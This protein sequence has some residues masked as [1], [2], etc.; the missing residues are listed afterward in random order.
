MQIIHNVK[1]ATLGNAGVAIFQTLQLIALIFFLSKEEMGIFAILI[2]IVGFAQLFVDA[3]LS[4]AILFYKVTDRETLG[5]LYI[6]NIFVGF[7]VFIFTFILSYF[8]GYIYSK[9]LIVFIQLVSVVFLI[10]SFGVQ[11][12]VLFQKDLMFDTLAKYD[13]FSNLLGFL[14]LFLFL[15]MNF[16]LFSFCYSLIVQFLI[17]NLL[18]VKKGKF[19]YSHSFSNLSMSKSREVLKFGFYQLGEKVANYFAS[20]VDV[21][22]IGR[23]LGLEVLGVYSIFKNILFKIISLINP[24]VTKISYTY[25]VKLESNADIKNMYFSS[26][27]YVCLIT[28][29]IYI[30]IASNSKFLLYI[31]LVDYIQ[32]NFILFFLSIYVALRAI[33]NPIGSLILALGKPKISFYWNIVMLIFMPFLIYFSS[34]YG[35]MVLV[36]SL[37][38]TF[39]ILKFFEY[40]FIVKVYTNPSSKD[41]IDSIFKPLIY[42]LVACGCALPSFLAENVYVK[43]TLFI[44]VFVLV[45][46]LIIKFFEKTVFANFIFLI[47][48][49]K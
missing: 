13:I 14:L 39:L 46:L 8:L 3:G 2:A 16:G 28:I 5:F 1:W 20:Q 45:Y 37:C 11:Y 15:K 23:V 43:V 10:N 31:F 47:G 21:F 34:L 40:Y 22:I 27:K 9:E 17:Y 35:L 25:M 36:I 49:K 4:N 32:Y 12:K 41:N 6:F 42:N 18:L 38:L 44:M 26:V 33:G 7:L 29:P 19:I 48:R 30:F 24:V